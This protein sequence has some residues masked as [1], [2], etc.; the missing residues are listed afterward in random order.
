[1]FKAAWPLQEKG[2]EGLYVSLQV[3]DKDLIRQAT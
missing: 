1:M 3:S 2:I